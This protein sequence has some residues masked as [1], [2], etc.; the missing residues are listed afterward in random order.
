MTAFSVLMSSHKE[1]N[2]WKEASE[3][4]NQKFIRGR[5]PAPFYKAGMPRYRGV[6]SPFM[7]AFTGH[8]RH[9]YRCGC[10]PL[11]WDPW[12]Y[13]VLPHVSR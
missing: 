2:A 6:S 1:N 4:E 5:R 9:A 3:A 12:R 13:S 8:A 11:W 10:V 7:I